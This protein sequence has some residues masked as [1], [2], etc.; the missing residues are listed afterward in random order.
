VAIVTS[1]KDEI[2]MTAQ[3]SNRATRVGSQISY[4]LPVEGV[5]FSISEF[6][7]FVKGPGCKPGG[8]ITCDYEW[9]STYLG[10]LTFN[11][12]PYELNCQAL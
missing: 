10:Y 8:R 11:G 7:Q 2:Q 6:S 4:K 9:S 12:K 3:V 5:S 1:Q